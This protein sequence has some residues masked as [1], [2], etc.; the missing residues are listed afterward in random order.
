MDDGLENTYVNLLTLFP[1]PATDGFTIDAGNQ[2]TYIS[3]YDSRGSL[4]LQ[5]QAIGD[6]FVK[7]SSLL[8]GLYVIKVNEK[9]GKFV[10][11]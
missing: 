2:L 4:V 9:I 3:I 11:N 6:T 5:Q 8:N 10:K 7:I 1:N